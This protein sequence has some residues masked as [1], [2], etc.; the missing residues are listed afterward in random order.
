MMT[1]AISGIVDSRLDSFPHL[2]VLHRS[3]STLTFLS[4]ESQGN[5]ALELC[6]RLGDQVNQAAW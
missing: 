6:G 4:P 3:K 5:G 1:S 2:F